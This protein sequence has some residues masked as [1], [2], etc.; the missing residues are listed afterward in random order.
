MPLECPSC[1]QANR[2]VA[3]FCKACGA[4]IPAAPPPDPLLQ[5]NGLVGMTEMKR[6]IDR[7]VRVAR[8]AAGRGGGRASAL[9]N[10][11]TII[12]GNTGTGKTHVAGIIFRLFHH[13]GLTAS[14]NYVRVDVVSVSE[15]EK[16]LEGHYKKAA[17]GVLFIDNA[18][19]LARPGPSG[20]TP[21]IERLLSRMDAS[22]H[23]P[24]VVLAGLRRDLRDRVED[25]PDLR[26]RF[27]YVFHLPDFEAGEL[28]EITEAH[29]RGKGLLLHPDA[30]ERVRLLLRH[31]VRTRDASF[32]NARVATDL[33]EALCLR[34][35][36]RVDG[37][38]PDDGVIQA[39][40][41]ESDAPPERTLDQIL[42]ELDGFVGMD[43]VKREVRALAQQIEIER[44]RAE[45]GM[46]RVGNVTRHFVITGN[47]G[48]G[49]TTVTRKLAE[50]FSAIGLLD[51][52]HVV[53]VD[54]GKLEGQYIG[55]AA[56]RVNQACDEAFGGVL[57]VD[58][59]Y[60]L[61]GSG[62]AGSTGAG[63]YGQ[64]AVDTLLK[65]MED[66]RGRFV[67]VV[68]GYRDRMDEFFRMNPGLPSRFDSYLHIDDYTP[69]E[70]RDI[71][72]QMAAAQQFRLSTEARE[73]LER[74]TKD[75]YDRRGRD[76]ANGRTVRQL[77]DQ[78]RSALAGRLARL[79]AGAVDDAAFSLIE[80]EDIVYDLPEA[81]SLEQALGELRKMVGMETIKDWIGDLARLLQMQ[82]ERETRTG[83]KTVL[84]LHVVLTGNPGTGKTSV[85]RILGMV[86]RTLG[87]L[88]R[89]QVVDVDRS[90]L[91]APFLG[92]TALKTNEA[93]DRALGG[94]LLVDEA[95]SLASDAFGREAID[96]LLKR[97][98][99]DRGKFVV[100]AAGYPEEMRQFLETN[101]GLS[102][103]FS[104]HFHIDDYRPAELLEVFEV[105]STE[106]GYTL[107]PAAREPLLRALDALYAARDRNFGNARTV[108]GLLEKSIVRQS[109][110][111]AAAA[112][113]DEADFALL[114]A[115]DIPGLEAAQPVD[116]AT[117]LAELD[118]LIGMDSIKRQVRALADFLVVQKARKQAGEKS[119]SLTLHFLFRGNPGTGKTTVA[120]VL[121]QV[122]KALGVL[123]KGHLVEVDRAGLVGSYLGQ[124]SPKTNDAVDRAMGGVLFVDE[125][126]ALAS[127][128]FGR[129]AI[130]TLLKR[131]EDDRGKFVVIA[132][133][134]H[135][136]MDRFLATNTGLASRFTQYVDFEDYTP[137]EMAE[138]FR[139]LLRTEGFVLELGADAA[140]EAMMEAVWAARNAAF[141]NGRTVRN[142]FDRAR[143][144]QA[145]RLA[146]A[147][148]GAPA[149]GS[150]L[151]L[152]LVSDLPPASG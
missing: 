93:I 131:M 119:S 17:G 15:F 117:S 86:L 24:V 71:F 96:T 63:S 108:R 132:A 136:E 105:M 90:G 141:A 10:L 124:T 38:D 102:S 18:H 31:R 8:A 137:A 3:R 149:D 151:N 106:Q 47:P 16:E 37:G 79:P 125:A 74:V 109:R 85:A 87:V 99:D 26:S 5:L 27:R 70:L 25:S 59:A 113:R 44:R 9:G 12:T 43:T 83:R 58:E 2:P 23:D 92:Q 62:A 100:V 42:A 67:V 45:Q 142:L 128:D 13:H 107:D 126:Y 88:P 40:D 30:E 127:D 134:Y 36:L 72:E 46:G 61:A 133:G 130:N 110:R 41:V 118:A 73:R 111:L 150:D 148:A 144:A 97:M 34:Y 95:Y 114:R 116:L 57:F 60:G 52:G 146:Q 21:P 68:A 152:I 120:R 77:F 29:V 75:M 129:E 19:R 89:G 139:H 84:K 80:A 94:V 69:T 121:A 54:P 98:E 101:P 48:T 103:R 50:I 28:L 56:Q 6:E 138:I 22:G 66:D 81:P 143:Q 64:K 7:L 65:R 49:K 76:F 1:Q 147:G 20:S 112:D 78:A 122:F 82:A 32:A 91:V 135:A 123:P 33:G 55:E 11:H 145:T 4:S 140:V 104:D 51:R 39:D 14:P 35:F 53:E 115:D